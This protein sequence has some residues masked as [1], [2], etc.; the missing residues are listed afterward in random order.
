MLVDVCS[1]RIPPFGSSVQSFETLGDAV[2]KRMKDAC[3]F[4]EKRVKTC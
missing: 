4:T 1:L 2:R 3:L